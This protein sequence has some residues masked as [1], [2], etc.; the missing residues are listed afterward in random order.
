MNKMPLRQNEIFT[1]TLMHCPFSLEIKISNNS[2]KVTKSNSTTVNTKKL[3]AKT[4]SKKVVKTLSLPTGI[5]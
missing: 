4:Q 2:L 3:R 5:T 1:Y